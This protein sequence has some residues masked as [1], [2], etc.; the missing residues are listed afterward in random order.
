MKMHKHRKRIFETVLD[1][2]VRIVLPELADAR[3]ASAVNK[4]KKIGFNV[5]DLNNFSDDY[6]FY[7]E[8]ICNKSFTKNW[9]EEMID[10]Y[11][12]NTLIQGLLML[13]NDKADCLVAGAITS[14]ADV[15]KSSIRLIGV[16]SN[17]VSSTFLMI[18][19]EADLAFT[20]S[21][22]GVI[23]EPDEKQLVSIAYNAA[24]SHKLLTSEEPR[25]VF[26]SFSTKGSAEHYKVKRIQNAVDLFS[27]KYPNIIH[28][29]EMQFDAAIDIDIAKSKHADSIIRGKGNVFIFPDLGA[30]NIAYKITQYLGRFEAWGPLLNGLNK[31]VHDLSR[32]TKVNDIISI[33]AIA[34]MESLVRH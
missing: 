16:K 21:D 20:Y 32:G 2:N 12:K 25:V 1:S 26:L 13:D 30:A 18:S 23:P 6:L 27:K 7:K 34:A 28:D 17:L 14:T 24:N 15:I 4:M 11:L 3:V 33:S 9:T 19:P 5:I 8:Y 29:G 31:P 22:C 10:N